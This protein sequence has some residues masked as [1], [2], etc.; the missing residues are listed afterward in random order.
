MPTAG[1]ILDKKTG[2]KVECGERIATL[3]AEDEFLFES[4]IKKLNESTHI[5]NVKPG[6]RSVVIDRIE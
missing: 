1:I 4:A 2:D 5:G 6:Q 3:Y